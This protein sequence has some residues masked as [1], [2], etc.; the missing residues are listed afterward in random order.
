MNKNYQN[1]IND[2]SLYVKC[3]S[4]RLRELMNFNTE[5][6]T[7]CNLCES[8][9]IM[10]IGANDR[11]G[12]PIRSGMC[13]NCGLIFL[14]DRFTADA[15]A[16]FYAKHY[17]PLVSAY[18]GRTVDS[19]T[20][21]PEQERYGRALVKTFKGLLDLPN[22]PKLIDIGGSTGKV[23]SAFVEKYNAEA[24]ILD[25]S[26]DELKVARQLRYET[27]CDLFETWKGTDEQFDLVLCCRTIDHFL[28]LKRSLAKLRGLC[29]PWGYLMI[30]IVDVDIIWQK[31]GILEAAIKVDHPYYLTSEITP[32]ILKNASFKIICSEIVSDPEKVTYLCQKTEVNENE[33][34]VNRDFIDKRVRAFQQ[35]RLN[36]QITEKPLRSP[37]RSI[38]RKLYHLKQ[39]LMK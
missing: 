33:S 36:M 5:V 7:S 16:D 32:Y 34:Y 9:D 27:I 19:Q 37:Y 3:Y 12:L 38:L 4:N 1:F 28:Y 18:L 11:Y 8:D 10:I 21:G 20:I 29:K 14:I 13:L 30:D 22:K 17:R 26:P 24:V 39:R 6:I 25:P 31:K 15:Y 23:A 2:Y 35:Y